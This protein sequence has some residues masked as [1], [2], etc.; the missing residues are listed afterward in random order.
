MDRSQIAAATMTKVRSADEE[1]LLR[2]SL[3]L[4]AASGVPVAVADGSANPTFDAFARSLE[5][6][7]VVVPTAGGLVGKIQASLARAA[8]WDTPFI[9]Y[10]E[11]DKETFFARHLRAFFRDA[12]DTA[13]VG[14]VL[15]A[16]SD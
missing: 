12:P 16:R 4:L 9:F 3:P 6:V 1:E 15:A 8:D 13:D 11:P 5:G 14:I 10:T 7:H 2:R